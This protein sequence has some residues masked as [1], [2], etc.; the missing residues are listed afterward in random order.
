MSDNAEKIKRLIRE[1]IIKNQFGEVGNTPIYEN[2]KKQMPWQIRPTELK[3]QLPATKAA[4]QREKK[5]NQGVIR[6]SNE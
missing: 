6:V 3:I 1:R 4:V 5:S 2:S